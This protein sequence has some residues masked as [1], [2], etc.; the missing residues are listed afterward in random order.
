MPADVRYGRD[1]SRSRQRALVLDA[2][3]AEH[4]ERFVR[5]A[6][7][8]PRLPTVAWINEPKEVIATTR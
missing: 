4:P 6:P 5:K 2:A 7:V 1:E 8:P 3:H